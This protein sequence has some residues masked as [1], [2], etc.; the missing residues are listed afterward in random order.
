MEKRGERGL[1]PRNGPIAIAAIRS[2]E[3]AAIATA[4]RSFPEHQIQQQHCD[5]HRGEHAPRILLAVGY[6]WRAPGP[7]Q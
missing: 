6:D 4:G 1:S 3:I 7:E 5:Q 2:A